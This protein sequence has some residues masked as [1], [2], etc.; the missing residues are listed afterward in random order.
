MQERARKKGHSFFRSFGDSCSSVALAMGIDDY[1]SYLMSYNSIELNNNTKLSTL[2]AL[3]ETFDPFEPSACT[4][5]KQHQ[6]KNATKTY[7]D[8]LFSLI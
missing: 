4:K 2:I 1:C 3:T 8:Y 6:Q 7:N 5:E